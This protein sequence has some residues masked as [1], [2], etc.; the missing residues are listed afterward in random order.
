VE[1]VTRDRMREM[2]RRTIEGGL[3]PG[4]TLMERAGA[5]ILRSILRRASPLERRRIVIA[6]GKGN[7]GGDGLVVARL[8]RE[9]GLHPRVLMTVPPSTLEG[10]AA[11]NA[12]RAER[13]GVRILEAG[14]RERADLAALTEDDLVLDALLGTGLSGPP[15]GEVVEWIRTV[16]AS[17]ARAVAVD[18]P[19]GLSADRGAIEG[20]GVRAAWTVTMARVKLGF[21]F[22]PAR[23]HVGEVDVVDIGI[24]S[25][26]GAA[27]GS[28]ALLSEPGELASWLPHP[29]PASHKGDWGK[30]LIVGG[31]PGLTGALALA[32]RA[33]L[34]SGAG[35]VRIGLP[36]SLNAI[37]EEKVT[38]AMTIPLPEG[39]DGQLLASAAERILSGFGDWDALVLGPGLGR[40]PEAE[41]LVMRLLGGWRGPILI[42][43]DALNALAAWGPDSW[44]P[45][46]RE[47]RAAGVAGGAVLT[48]H[49]GEMSRLTGR[50]IAELCSDPVGQAREW[51]QRWG[52]T[53]VL[54][55]APSVIASPDG[56]VRVNPTGN[57]G[58]ATGGSGD[59]LSGII[60]ALLGQGLS[61]VRAA[62]LG[63]YLHGLA[64]DLAVAG[65]A[66][67]SLLPGDVAGGLGRALL[68]LEKRELP[69]GWRWR[70]LP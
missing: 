1:L 43:A 62:T 42:D 23:S 21:L 41:R 3:V 58:L 13:A 46:A 40:F 8:L 45:R 60:G 70:S 69:P 9:R 18:I 11:I 44:V 6:C 51:A 38:E 36:R 65:I 47:V 54:K 67:R 56:E 33:A 34:H 22:S 63:C 20:E 19:S 16:N 39:E 28:D 49:P 57:S 37:L 5:G 32:A 59:V 12:R 66:R 24:P 52:V 2:D 4:L 7:N 27:V 55:G 35:L 17:P 14:P 53:L 64:A 50:S 61:G 10:D 26:V 48:P 68:S 15:R 25:A 29:G 31:S 30:I